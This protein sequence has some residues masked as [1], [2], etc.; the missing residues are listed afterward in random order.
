ML[1][2]PPFPDTSLSLQREG[3]E[4]SNAP[5]EPYPRD[6]HLPRP[7]STLP[8]FPSPLQLK[9]RH[10][11]PISIPESPLADGSYVQKQAAKSRK[12]DNKEIWVSNMIILRIHG[13]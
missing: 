4:L 12:D 2:W 5:L 11:Q 1:L 8:N 10:Q 9:T 7:K 13:E 3:I 6:V